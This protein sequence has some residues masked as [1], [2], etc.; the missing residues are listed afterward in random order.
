MY[1]KVL[2]CLLGAAVGDAMGAATETK[3]EQQ[4]LK[5]F[6]HRVVGFETPPENCLARGRKKGQITDAFSIP[7]QIMELLIEHNGKAS[8]KLGEEALLKWSET[9][10][11]EPFAGMTTRN[12]I[13]NLQGDK[14]LSAWAY[15]GHLGTKLYKGHYY[16]L[17]SN[18]AASKAYTAGI[19]HPGNIDAAINDVIELTMA[20]HD[21]PFSL[22]GAAAIAAAV[23]TALKTE[24]T[25]QH[26]LDAALFGSEEGERKAR[27][28]TDIW[29]YPGPSV[30]KRIRMALTI[31]VNSE[32]KENGVGEINRCIG[33]G[34][35]IS[36]T[37][38]TA[39]AIVLLNKENTME[40]IY[41]AVNI[42]DETSATA[43]IVG[44][45]MGAKNG[46]ESIPT[47]YLEFLQQENNLD[48]E[49]QA[50]K[51]TSLITENIV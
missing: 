21:D 12:A 40:A 2:G 47:D 7:Y 16:A 19:I 50:R 37:V 13:K 10:Y 45:I 33:N 26:I 6:G 38:P 5:T 39:L 4:I 25:I 46:F 22:S 43:C 27:L 49:G 14:E 3:S 23:S 35:A 8:R 17:S 30:T 31:V 11:Y 29:D 36:E 34:P 41:D 18:G 51:I 9:E 20:S 28:R 1:D 48:L 32:T 42:G 15:A 24:V 44:A